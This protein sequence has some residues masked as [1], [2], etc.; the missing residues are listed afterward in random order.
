MKVHRY[1]KR[2]SA[3]SSYIS[4]YIAVD[5]ELHNSV[6]TRLDMPYDIE[7]LDG[8]ELCT[9]R[10]YCVQML[11][12]SVIGEYCNNEHVDIMN[13][14][15]NRNV[16]CGTPTFVVDIWS[17]CAKGSIEIIRIKDRAF[18]AVSYCWEPWGEQFSIGAKRCAESRGLHEAPSSTVLEEH[19]GLI[20]SFSRTCDVSGYMK[21]LGLLLRTCTERFAWIDALCIPQYN[22]GVLASELGR[23]GLYYSNCSL[24]VVFLG[25]EQ[26]IIADINEGCVPRWFTRAWTHQ[27]HMLSSK[28]IYAIEQRHGTFAMSENA[29]S[30]YGHLIETC[31]L[32][33]DA[34]ALTNREMTCIVKALMLVHYQLTRKEQGC[35]WGVT[36]VFSEVGNRNCKHINDKLNSVYGLFGISDVSSLPEEPLA[37]AVKKLVYSL[38]ATTAAKLIN[39]DPRSN[40]FKGMC[41]FPLLSNEM[42]YYVAGQLLDNLTLL[43]DVSVTDSGLSAS[44]PALIYIGYS[45]GTEV[46][47]LE[48][49]GSQYELVPDRMQQLIHVFSTAEYCG[50]IT[51]DVI[52]MPCKMYG[53]ITGKTRVQPEDDKKCRFVITVVTEVRCLPHESQREDCKHVRKVG[54]LMLVL[55]RCVVDS[56]SRV[57]FI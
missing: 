38:P 22:G 30:L 47:I 10:T 27:E 44:A 33:V 49:Y 4:S 1:C 51:Y 40:N 28:C 12:I 3:C 26:P 8:D 37:T 29:A 23:M 50:A 17:S 42:E 46:D 18:I 41:W 25:M 14:E 16:E 34:L 48:E 32:R 53:I 43:R 55:D 6:G 19:P 11:Q 24:S 52:K 5:S 13:T 45:D 36:D 7:G 2:T 56:Y 54:T 21:I 9:V 20:S 35:G 39:I 57:T 15:L 31:A